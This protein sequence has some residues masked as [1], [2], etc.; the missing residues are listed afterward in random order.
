MS[1]DDL[2]DRLSAIHPKGFDLSLGRIGT[3][4]SRL[5][6]PHLAIPPP[7]HIAGT[8][9]K[10]STIAFCRAALEASGHAVHVHTS[11]HLVS[12]RERF[13]LADP[14]GG[15]LVADAMLEDAIERVVEANDGAA[16]TIFELLT[17]A[18]FLLFSEHPADVCLI[19]VGLGG[20]FDA[21][22][23]IEMP[24][25]SVITNIALDHQAYLGDRVEIIAAEK[26]GII[27]HGCPVIIGQQ[28][29]LVR[30]VLEE[31]ALGKA[32]P[33]FSAG[34]DF[35]FYGQGGRFLYQDQT[36]LIDLP[37]PR[38]AGAHQ[39]SNAATA[40]AALRFSDFDISEAAFEKAMETVYWP[41]R[42]E[43][44]RSGSLEHFILATSPVEIWIDGGH[45]PAAGV[46][47]AH[48][49][50]DLDERAPMPV[51]IISGML[52]T[53]DPKGYFEAF[54]GLAE[55]V[56][57]VPILSSDAGIDPRELA[58]I[59][60]SA[61]LPATSCLSVGDA[62][63]AISGLLVD[64]EPARILICGSLYLVGE[65]LRSNGTPPL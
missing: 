19:E 52:N 56:F 2:I 54:E 20:R 23:V 6:D 31:A 24:R 4:L 21:T 59:V 44:L 38:L 14:Q 45:N 12:W 40:I 34:Q 47:V 32:S 7:I 51:F 9:G 60:K 10:G 43:R 25:A 1:A 57:T 53:K 30:A 26:A 39:L 27:K 13:R 35:F 29:D 18:M 5:G 65:V 49:L 16:I 36:G 55:W 22:N 62:L 42:M 63:N 15:R 17:A 61:G 28:T 3:V 11:P 50:A 48:F 46:V 41:G 58:D 33:S 8:N 64:G 37:T